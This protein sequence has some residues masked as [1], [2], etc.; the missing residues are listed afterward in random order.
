MKILITAL[1]SVILGFLIYIASSSFIS[2]LNPFLSIT[3]FFLISLNLVSIIYRIYRDKNKSHKLT[4][5]LIL[6]ALV[7][8]TL[9]FAMIDSTE[10]AN[11]TSYPRRYKINKELLNLV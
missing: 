2:G 4:S 10:V 3:L 7:I 5:I 9:M 6:L 8:I 1:L 11:D